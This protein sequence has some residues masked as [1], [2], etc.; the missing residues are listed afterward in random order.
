MAG[1][2]STHSGDGASTSGYSNSNPNT[3]VNGTSTKSRSRCTSTNAWILI[4]TIFLAFSTVVN[5]LHGQY[6]DP[7][8]NTTLRFLHQFLIG[9]REHTITKTRDHNQHH[10]L[11]GLS[12]NLH[13]GPFDGSA[14]ENEMVYWSDIPSDYTYQSP[15]HRANEG[16]EK[17]LTFEPDHGYVFFLSKGGKKWNCRVFF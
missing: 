12:C 2:V 13:G 11:A 8:D 7:A 4:I 10:T 5:F 9:S 16:K 17:F 15:F 1:L 14:V 3:S 6:V